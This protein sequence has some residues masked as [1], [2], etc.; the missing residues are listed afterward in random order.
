MKVLI[1]IL[2][3]NSQQDLADLLRSN[4]QIQGFT[5]S[6]VEGHGVQE[7]HDS[8]L[9]A[10]DKVVG[11]VPRVRVD[12]LLEDSHVDAVL[13]SVR[14]LSKTGSELGVFWVNDVQNSGRL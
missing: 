9:S 6:H 10:R 7:V 14:T 4:K 13:E 5:F 1:M 12:I 3:S 11:Y 2:H 8:L